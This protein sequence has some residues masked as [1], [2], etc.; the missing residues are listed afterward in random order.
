MKFFN[1]QYDEAQLEQLA[2]HLSFDTM[3]S[4]ESEI[5]IFM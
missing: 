2:D 1:K 3:R 5:S 4:K